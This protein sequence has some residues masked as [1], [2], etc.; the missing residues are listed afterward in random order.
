MRTIAIATLV[1]TVQALSA[2][3]DVGVFAGTGQSL[4]Q[5]TTADI[6]LFSIDVKILLV[7][8][9]FLFDG[10]VPGL[11]QAEYDCKFVL[12]NLTDEACEVRAG[13]P[14]DSG[15]AHPTEAENV[16]A[17]D[18]VSEYSFIAREAESTYHPKV[19]WWRNKRSGESKALFNWT[20]KFEPKQTKELKVQYR[21]SMS[22]SIVRTSKR[23]FD[24]DDQA[25]IGN[26][27]LESSL[28]AGSLVEFA[29]Y[30][31]ETGSSG[32]GN[33]ERATFRIVAAP[34]ERY[35]NHRPLI[36]CLPPG[37]PDDDEFES[38]ADKASMRALMTRHV[39]WYRE[40][41]PSGWRA[42]EGGVQWDYKDFKPSDPIEIRY[43]KT[44]VPRVPGEIDAWIDDLCKLESDQEMTP[45]DLA[46][47]KQVVLAMYGQ[48]PKDDLA[49]KFAEDQVWYH[50]RKSFSLLSLT[51][52]QQA[53][54]NVIDRRIEAMKPKR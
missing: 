44:F 31:T 23:G 37:V 14:I 50:P 34:F 24:P 33:V 30:T 35:L 19:G 16:A 28:L 18:W 25:K 21:L 51:P 9:R 8:G 6:Q 43:Y 12:R 20:M 42:D 54:L 48:E 40:I 36:E 49:R 11:D 29:G 7:R 52:D 27:W 5:I 32:A 39:W 22:E 17:T 53:I 46:L 3:G 38:A 41:K 4:Q 10:T 45:E 47:I 15:L 2:S 1:V 13:F 26:P